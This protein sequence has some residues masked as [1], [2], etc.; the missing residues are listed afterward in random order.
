MKHFGLDGSGFA[1]KTLASSH[2]RCHFCSMLFKNSIKVVGLDA[3]VL[4]VLSTLE[5][6]IPHF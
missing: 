2:L 6:M 3:T 1:S 4:K 5:V